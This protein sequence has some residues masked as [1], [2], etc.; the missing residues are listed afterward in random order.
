MLNL[1]PEIKK[2]RT[3]EMKQHNEYVLRMILFLTDSYNNKN[4]LT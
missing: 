3:R 4:I 2:N 1:C